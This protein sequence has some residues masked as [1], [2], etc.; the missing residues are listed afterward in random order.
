MKKFLFAS[1]IALLTIGFISAPTLRAEDSNQI[2]IKDP[3]EFNAYQFA[4]SQT[5]AK[6]KASQLENFLTT[7]PNSVVKTTVLDQ[8]MDSYQALGDADSALKAAN[9]LLEVD[10]NNLKAIFMAVYVKKTQCGKTQDAQTCDDAAAFAK[11]G[12]LISKPT[13]VSD[14]DW[15]KQ[16]AAT[17]PSF[18]SAIALDY[19]IAKKDYKSAINEYKA[20][21]MLYTD[22]QTKTV[23][24]VDML[25]LAQAYTMP[26]AKDLVQACWFYARVWNFAPAAYK[27]Q[28]EPKL[29][30]YYKKY[31]GG[32]DG[33]DELKTQAQAST[34]PPGTLTIKAAAT[35]AEVIHTLIESTPDLS[36]LALADKET[37]LAVGSKEDADKLW[38]ILK[39]EMTP[40]PGNVIEAAP[41]AVKV[42]VT[43]AKTAAKPTEY[44]VKLNAPITCDAT[45][46]AATDLKAQEDYIAANGVK[47]DADKLAAIFASDTDKVT[48]IALEVAVPTIKMAVTD[49]AKTEKVADFIV[50]MKAPISCKEAPAVG[51]TFGLQGKGDAELDGTYD[52]YTQIPATNTTTAAALIVLKDAFIQA[53]EKKK[54]VTPAKPAA[55]KKATT[56][57]TRKTTKK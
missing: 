45:L 51:Y 39:G 16:T 30:Y 52:S 57:P 43:T 9:R 50:N 35:P 36:K 17:H 41:A 7:Y 34:F 20:E 32:L 8:L 56:T 55:G 31:H 15:K 42:T 47:E 6:T 48:K 54:A 49:D 53:P 1:A 44:F 38:A 18:H 22:E 4:T 37:V 11:K 12:L 3:A 28:I 26:D 23:G 27:A 13:N 5:D 33:L 29:E 46:P 21:L 19:A 40:V 25:Q 14:D 2:T 24:L 10:A